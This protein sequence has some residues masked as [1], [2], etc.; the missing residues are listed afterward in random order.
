MSGNKP[1]PADFEELV[2]QYL[3]NSGFEVRREYAVQI[4]INGIRKKSHK[5]DWG[6]DTLLVECKAN[7]WNS[8]SIPSGERQGLNEA[9]LFP[10]AAP[11]SYRKM[12][13]MWETGRFGKPNPETLAEC[14]VRL[15]G[16]LIPKD[17]EVY[18]LEENNL[19]A[20]RIWPPHS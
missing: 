12:L 16:H 1:S 11:K 4:S 8:R 6:N 14:Y 7:N 2:G 3:N 17:V 13:F 20:N 15:Y 9:I 18:E 19:S 5:F 10:M